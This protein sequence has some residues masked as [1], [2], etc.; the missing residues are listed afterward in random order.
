MLAE[1]LL[2]GRGELEGNLEDRDEERKTGQ[3]DALDD[4]VCEAKERWARWDRLE[5][6]RGRTSLN[7]RFSNRAMI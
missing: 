1:V 6:G 2:G 4:D 5:R 3:L 7:P